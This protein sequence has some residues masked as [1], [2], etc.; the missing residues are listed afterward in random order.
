MSVIDNAKELAALIQKLGN[1][2]LYRR[3][4]ELEGE[5]IEL[6]REKHELDQ[7]LAVQDKHAEIIKTL[8]FDSPFYVSQDKQ[9]LFCARCIESC[10]CAVHVVKTN[11]IERWRYWMCPECKT[12][13]IDM[14]PSTTDR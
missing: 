4:V 13:Y 10:Q 1:T 14:R 12:E 7:R 9:E 11:K 2:D 3:I 6:T 8:R 5:I